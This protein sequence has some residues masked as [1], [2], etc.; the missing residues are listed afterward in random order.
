MD[1]KI[2]DFLCKST[3]EPI[4]EEKT[5]NSEEKTRNSEEKTRKTEEKLREKSEEKT[6]KTEKTRNF[7]DKNPEEKARNSE[8]RPGKS[9]EKRP[10]KLL[11]TPPKIL[12]KPQKIL[13]KHEISEENPQKA[14]ILLKK[15]DIWLLG[16]LLFELIHGY[17]PYKGKTIEEKQR[18]ILN[19]NQRKF[20]SFISDEAQELISAI[21]SQN[22][23]KR[24]SIKE[25]LESR[26]IKKF[27]RL[28]NVEI[29]DFLHDEMI[30]M[31]KNEN[32]KEKTAD[33]KEKK[34]EKP[35]LRIISEGF[36]IAFSMIFSLFFILNSSLF[37]P[38]FLMHFSFIFIINFS[39]IF[40]RFF[41]AFSMIFSLFFIL[42]F[43]YFFGYFQ[44]NF[45][46][47]FKCLFRIQLPHAEHKG[48]LLFRALEFEF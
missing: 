12:E 7:S 8:R 43:S 32:L 47:K 21:L 45:P 41:L 17:F 9:E 27:E 10:Q 38:L 24:P 19:G 11:E 13:E 31:K 39:L 15:H 35:N 40:S 29:K 34:K 20:A 36:F 46:L 14:A 4:W 5:R 3:F 28:F 33:F 25:I 42:N 30:T 22:P 37:F 23:E 48:S 44:L 1:V 16:V 2:A 26:W 6:R 18:S